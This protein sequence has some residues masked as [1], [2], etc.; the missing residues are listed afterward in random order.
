MKQK[1]KID[2]SWKHIVAVYKKINGN[3]VIQ[4]NY[5]FDNRAYFYDSGEVSVDVL[6]IVADDSYSRGGL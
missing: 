4:E 2:G 3:W 1:I 6:L 5:D